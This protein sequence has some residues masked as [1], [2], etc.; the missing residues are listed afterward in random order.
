[1]NKKELEAWKAESI[2]QAYAEL[3]WE[4]Y[5]QNS[6]QVFYGGGNVR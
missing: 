1:M 2:K 5:M 4:I 3:E 6:G